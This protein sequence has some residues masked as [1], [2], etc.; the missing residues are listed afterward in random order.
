MKRKLSGILTL[1]LVLV[2]QI[3]FAQDNLITG[4]VTNGQGMPLPG[5]NVL[6]KNT[7][8]GTQTDFDGNYAIR[9]S[10]GEVLVFS[11]VGFKA[12]EYVIDESTTRVNLTLEE[13]A[14][15]LEEVVVVAYGTQ[16]K[17]SIVGSVVSLG[18]E[19]LEEQQ[20]TTVTSALQGN[21]PGVN[22]LTSGGQP[23]ENPTIRIRGIG[24]INAS[25][26]PLIIVDGAPFNGNI[27]SISADQI[28]S[29]NV[30][31]DASSTALY[32]SR[33]SNGVIVIT[34]KKGA[35]NS[36]PGL[37][38][39]AIGGVSTPAVELH[40]VLG[41]NQYMTYAWEASRNAYVA[42]GNAP[43]AAGQLASNNLISQLGYNPYDVAQ[44]VDANGN[45]VPGANLL[46]ETDWEDEILRSAALRQEYTVGLN[47]GGE[48]TRY[49][50]SAN[51][52]EQ[53]GSVKESNFE[54][55]TTR[56]NLESD[57]RDWLKVGLNTA[58][59]TSS[60][61]Y[62]TQSGSS[63]QSSIQWIYSVASLYPLYRRDEQGGLILD[64]F[65]DPI[66]DYGQNEGLV[67]ASRPVFNNE[68]A[69]GS[70]YKYRI[71]NKR[72]NFN[73]NGFAEL[74]FTDYLSFRSNLSYEQYVFDSY[75]YA[76]T[77][78]GYASNVGGRITQN[79]NVTTTT[80]FINSLNFNKTFGNHTIN[81]DAI[82]EAYEV[83]FDAFSA[84]GEG[85]L[86]NVY[87]LSGRTTPTSAS[88][89][90]NSERLVG[91]LGRLG[92]NYADKYFIEGSYRRDGSS[93]FS[94][95]TRWGDF[96]SVGG[97]W[98][99]SDENFLND[100]T[101]LN[102]LKLK[103]SYGELG[104]N[105]ILDS[106]GNTLY[107]PY[108]QAF[109]T[110]WNQGENTGVLLGGVVDPLLTWETTA[111]LNVGLDFTLLNN[112][113]EG[114]VEYYNKESV[115]LIYSQ[116]LAP[117]TGNTDITTNVGS[118]RNYGLEFMLRTRNIITD[119]FTWSTSLNFSVDNNEITE[120]TQDSFISGTKRWE[121]GRSLY[122]FWIQ[123]YAGVDPATGMALWYMDV[124]NSAGEQTGER[125]LTSDYSQADRY[126]VGESL[127]DI[128]GGFS[129]DFKYKNFDLN[130]LFNFSFGAQLYDYDY[131]GLMDGFGTLGY[132][133]SPDLAARWQEPGDITKVPKL[134]NANQDFGSTSTR[135][136]FD[137]DYVRLKAV[138]LGY[139]L[140]QST[141]ESLDLSS[142][143]LYLRGDNLWTWQTHD[144][145]DPEQ[146]ISGTTNSRSY[147]LKTVSLGL[148][149]KF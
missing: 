96:Y 85:F 103:G 81:A 144:G 41:T 49:F 125:T 63:Y 142:L 108:I 59:S 148:N 93:R 48:K 69:V 118:I 77:E 119:D 28:E 74:T 39:T 53:E 18:E 130:A 6:V 100:S 132:Q 50:L 146:S 112:R 25:A 91:Y 22:M 121:E 23:G 11:Y 87:S 34:T 124:E 94:A 113:V 13:D 131:A 47:G 115:D 62:P 46:W 139:N 79:R 105:N 111:M 27:N 24:S 35:F 116:P 82:M 99:I 89:S 133:Q 1:L 3:A 42:A 40:D 143:R 117:S 12:A 9:A 95:D 149:V 83:E 101:V 5:V 64:G 88:G 140:P 16:S 58:Y 33:G 106:D 20:L 135:F 136:L 19:V 54:R 147:I 32:G 102:Y 8:R 110:G 104:N 38:V 120:L 60:Q 80:N 129:T 134:L 109:E 10:E 127:P 128:I 141:V 90:I 107:F 2:V 15:Q 65:G 17:R 97:S 76:D 4:T 145:V 37:T 21:V 71:L 137:N 123:E 14:A 70:L 43:A 126:Y 73:A 51:Y 31:K 26:E 122:E 92:Y 84:A 29:M 36:E 44:P 75:N 52:L 57:V 7:S 55:V 138:T 61:N 78:V 68:N 66:Y 98:V 30:L 67:N 45:L 56:L 72:H 86:P 114:S